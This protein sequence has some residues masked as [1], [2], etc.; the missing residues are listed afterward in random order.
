MLRGGLHAINRNR[1]N[2]DKGNKQS[3]T[4]TTKKS[5]GGGG[6]GGGYSAPS[7]GVVYSSEARQAP[8]SNDTCYVFPWNETAE[9]YQISTNFD[10][11]KAEGRI[12]EGMLNTIFRDIHS[13][14]LISPTRFEPLKWLAFITFFLSV[15]LFFIYLFWGLFTQYYNYEIKQDEDS[16]YIETSTTA[17]R[18]AE[19]PIVGTFSSV[20][21]FCLGCFMFRWSKRSE[22][23]TS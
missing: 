7:A 5:Y 1:N 23:H 19:I 10:K 4:T 2:K 21:G 15:A 6:Y 20:L 12:N 18:F 17:G 13:I 9:C 22:E 8:A 16:R 14:R 11:A 3:G